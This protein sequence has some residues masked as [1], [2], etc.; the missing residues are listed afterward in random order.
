LAQIDET[1]PTSPATTPEEVLERL[2]GGEGV[3]HRHVIRLRRFLYRQ[4]AA[5]DE[6]FLSREADPSKLRGWRE[7]PEDSKEREKAADFDRALRTLALWSKLECG[8][9]GAGR[10]ETS[11]RPSES[12]AIG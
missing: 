4:W 9:W 5:L 6:T 1:A 12:C 2:R 10:S 3:P 8:L 11:S 7:A